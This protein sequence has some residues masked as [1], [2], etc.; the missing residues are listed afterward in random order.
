MTSSYSRICSRI[1]KEIS[2]WKQNLESKD[3]NVN[4]PKTKVVVSREMVKTFFPSDKMVHGPTQHARKALESIQFN[5]NCTSYE[6]IRHTMKS[7]VD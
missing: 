4:L 5:K 1:E 3:L 2:I 6:H 7:Q